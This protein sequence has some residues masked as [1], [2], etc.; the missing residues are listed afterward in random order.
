MIKTEWQYLFKNKKIL[1]ILI[2]MLAI[3]TIYAV[4]F[5]KSMWD[6]YGRLDQLP[7]AVVNQDQ[8]VQYQKHKM[9]IGSQLA[10]N[11]KKSQSLDYHFVSAKRAQ[12]GIKSGDYYMVLTI[13]KD[14]SKNATTLLAD[15]PQKMML[16]YE[17]TSGRSFISGKLSATAVE[18]MGN[19]ISEQIT[20]TYAKTMFA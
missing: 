13:P 15:K 12:S 6:P 4:I 9:A 20:E 2:G 16:K 19:Q 8:P 10:Q 1:A 3:P 11:L 17:T 14:F 7:V 18:K 5:L